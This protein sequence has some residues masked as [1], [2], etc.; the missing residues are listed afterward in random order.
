MAAQAE[1]VV[2]S[3]SVQHIW[4]HPRIPARAP[5]SR[6]LVLAFAAAFALLWIAAW[7]SVSTP[8]VAA[9]QHL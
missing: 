2:M 4:L 9:M 3:N 1:E 5:L 6:N 7:V 8:M